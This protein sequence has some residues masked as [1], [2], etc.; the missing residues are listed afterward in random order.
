MCRKCFDTPLLMSTHNKV[1]EQTFT[2]YRTSMASSLGAPILRV[3]TASK[4]LDCNTYVPTRLDE[5]AL[6]LS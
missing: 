1:G 5:S 3:N 4:S 2:N 6:E